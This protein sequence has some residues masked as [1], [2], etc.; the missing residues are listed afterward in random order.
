MIELGVDIGGTFTDVVFREAG[1]PLKIMKVPTTRQ[2]PSRAVLQAIE[3]LR[4]ELGLD[5]SQVV[6]FVHGTTI[7]TNCVLEKTG[8]KTGL[9]TTFGFK[10]ILEIG[11]QMRHSTYSA[12]PH[13]EAPVFLAPG[14]QRQEVIERISAT[15][16]VVTPINLDSLNH[17]IDAL[18]G[19]DV[20]AISICFLH[21]YLNPTH[22]RMA[23][24]VIKARYP[25]LLVSLSCEVD[26]AFREHERTVVTT[27][28]AY[29]KPR[30]D[31]YLS[32]LEHGLEVA[33]VQ[34][35]LQVMQSRGGIASSENARLRPIRLFLSGPAAGVIGAQASGQS[36]GFSNL[37]SFDVGGTST[38]I[39]LI[40]DER[41]LIRPQ[42]RVG[43]YPVRVP[44]VDVNAIGAG[45]GG[46]A[47]IDSSGGLRVGPQSAGSEPGPVCYGRGGTEPTVTDA[48]VVLGYVNPNYFAGGTIKLDAEL[49]YR[50]IENRIAQPLGLSVEAAALGIHRI[51]TAQMAEG[52]RFV[53]TREGFD[54]RESTLLPLGG[55][56]GIH[57]CALAEDL[58]MTKILVPPHPGVL[59]AMGL[60]FA[61]TEHEVS[62]A[63]PRELL[64]LTNAELLAAF[65]QL[66]NRCAAL[67]AREN[68]S[69]QPCQQFY[70]ADV[71][72]IGQGH[73][74]E[75]P[76]TLGSHIPDEMW[77]AFRIQYDR[78]FG[79]STDAPARIVNLRVVHRVDAVPHGGIALTN[80]ATQ[81]AIKDTRMILVGEQTQRIACSIYDRD[82]VP[83]GMPIKGPA[84]IEQLDTT[85]VVYPDWTF[86]A[87]YDGSIILEREAH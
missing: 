80:T 83:V 28:D 18:V 2:D 58:G 43:G 11:R 46:I 19:N 16:D 27:F 78:I 4:T 59:A 62:Q 56:G 33:G 50:S 49:S 1:K 35:P 25:N 55:G 45:G 70:Y 68:T 42:G 34:C 74:I 48:S 72:Y 71:C 61:P 23:Q 17:A 12:Q 38:D 51:V 64:K 47:W 22:E 24:E 3:K 20:E 15:G 79:H 9:L 69:D 31:T 53:S 5:P 73:H 37:V 7:A 65:E 86:T 44:M 26:P 8:S 85:T 81:A 41:P 14:Q 76:V 39:A 13:V 36:A 32:N 6:R 30:V 57:A 66:D 21:S 87:L 84:V 52:I 40:R 63:F 75:V 67:M 29:I 54:P 77:K 60:L 10:D 82:D